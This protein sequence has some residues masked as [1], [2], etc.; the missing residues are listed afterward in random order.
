V[1]SVAFS[2]DGNTLASASAD[3]TIRLW[4]LHTHQLFAV[5]T[6]HTAAVD[7]VAFSSDGNTLASSSWDKTIRLWE[8]NT[9]LLQRRACSYTNRNLTRDEWKK[10][11][12]LAFPYER[13][14]PNLPAGR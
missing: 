2:P 5:L 14:C 6:G 7:G 13:T 1:N 12:G 8:V 11:I 10:Y 3:D 9:A 4:D